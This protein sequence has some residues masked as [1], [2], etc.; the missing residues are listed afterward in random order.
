MMNK[1]NMLKKYRTRSKL[2]VQILKT[3]LNNKYFPVVATIQGFDAEEFIACFTE[4]G[5]FYTHEESDMDLVEVSP[6]EHLV[7]DEP[8]MVRDKPEEQWSRAY[9]AGVSRNSGRPTVWAG[10]KTSW[11]ALNNELYEICHA[12]NECR[13][14][15]PEELSDLKLLVY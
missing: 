1:I 10:G 4:Y 14:P 6:F 13:S 11:T 5:G 15:T 9:F 3:N 7:I 2:P 12:Y 8:V